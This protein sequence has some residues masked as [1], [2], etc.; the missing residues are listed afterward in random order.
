MFKYYLDESNTVLDMIVT[1]YNSVFTINYGSD[2]SLNGV[3]VLEF[4]VWDK[5]HIYNPSS[6]SIKIY[7]VSLKVI[8]IINDK[9]DIGE[10]WPNTPL[11]QCWSSK[12]NWIQRMR[13]YFIYSANNYESK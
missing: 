2:L 3:L 5:F 12:C 1:Q 10:S 4:K 7:S 13:N 11:L 8:D 6:I 9:Y